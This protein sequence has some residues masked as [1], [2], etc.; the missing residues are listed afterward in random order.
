MRCKWTENRQQTHLKCW[1]FEDFFSCNSM[2]WNWLI[3]NVRSSQRSG[4][5]KRVKLIS[6]INCESKSGGD[7]SHNCLLCHCS[8]FIKLDDWCRFPCSAVLAMLWSGCFI[9]MRAYSACACVRRNMCRWSSVF[10]FLMC[11]IRRLCFSRSTCHSHH[12]RA[13][14]FSLKSYECDFCWVL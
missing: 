7:R 6:T 9:A 5:S 1:F 4:H 3:A 8:L 11:F 2:H 13:L 14:F 12:M 10:F